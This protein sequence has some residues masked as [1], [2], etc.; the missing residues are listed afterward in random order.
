MAA[1]YFFAALVTI[2]LIGTA[3]AVLHDTLERGLS[4]RVE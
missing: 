3:L 1:W 4:R 2:S